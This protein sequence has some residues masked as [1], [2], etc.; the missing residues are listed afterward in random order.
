MSLTTVQIAELLEY[1]ERFVAEHV[2]CN[3]PGTGYIV[4][5]NTCG[6]IDAA[7][8]LAMK[9]CNRPPVPLRDVPEQENILRGMLA[10]E[11]KKLKCD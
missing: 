5:S 8:E 7:V 6:S 10:Q 2:E 1:A 9:R 4:S 11:I 3:S